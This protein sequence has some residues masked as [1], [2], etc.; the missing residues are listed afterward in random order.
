M[1]RRRK[2]DPLIA[3]ARIDRRV[4]SVLSFAQADDDRD[5]WLGQSINSRLRQVEL[6]RRINY[7]AA[8]TG[9]MKKVLEVIPPPVK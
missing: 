2:L 6:L 4:I 8:A 1:K 9:R 3:K 7:G 5:Y